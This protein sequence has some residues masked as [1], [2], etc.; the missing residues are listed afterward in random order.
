MGGHGA[1]GDRGAK[2]AQTLNTADLLV[3]KIHFFQRRCG[4]MIEKLMSSLN[5]K[6]CILMLIR[7]ASIDYGVG[8]LDSSGTGPK[9]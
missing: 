8:D 6:M 2:N 9:Y 5:R 4:R 3:R 1:S 7:G